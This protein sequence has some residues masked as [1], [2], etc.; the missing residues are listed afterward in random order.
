MC[1]FAKALSHG[2]STCQAV[3]EVGG[4]ICFDRGHTNDPFFAI[5]SV[6]K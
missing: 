4:Y 3:L 6:S 2:A 1:L 5:S